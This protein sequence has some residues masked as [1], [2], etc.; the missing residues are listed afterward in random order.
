MTTA[1]PP[2]GSRTAGTVL[3]GGALA[4]LGLGA[5]A[6]LAL[7]VALDPGVRS[8]FDATLGPERPSAVMA[9]LDGFGLV[10]PGLVFAI[11]ALAVAL[12]VGV[13]RRDVGA[14][15]SA[16][17]AVTW[18]ALLLAAVS[19]VR[20]LQG[21]PWLVDGA[22]W[23]VL[24]GGV[25][26][27]ALAALVATVLRT[28]LA[29]SARAPDLREESLVARESRTAWILLVPALL[30]LLV[31]AARPLEATVITSLTDKRFASDDV[32]AFVG[33]AN[34]RQ[35]L[36]LRFDEVACRTDD[37]GACV[38]GPD[39]QVR[40]EALPRELLLDG[41]R[42]AFTWD[43]P[44]VTAPDRAIAV[45]AL[46]RTW[47][48]SVWVTLVFAVASVSLELVIGLFI[49][50]T[51]HSEFRGRGAMRAVMLVPWAIPTV[52]SAR[53]WEL[54]LKDSSAGLVNRVLM[55]TGAI[56]SPQAWLSAS[57]LQLPSA[58]MIDV[59]K[60]SPFM[61][62]LLLAGL[63]VI[64]KELYESARV[65]GASRVREFF[66]ITLP[67]LR[68]AIAVAL[69]FRTLDA[70]RVFD[71]FNVLFGRSEHSVSTYTYEALINNQQAGYASAIGVL[72]FFL[73]F[74]IA[75]LYVRFLGVNRT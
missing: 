56:E 43:L 29:R 59:W 33:L 45:N 44:L 63:Q 51:V 38:R 35:L 32:P 6:A 66:A 34:Y 57:G 30:I 21:T 26:G 17:D 12:G 9:F 67:L 70:L 24:S 64:P 48:R 50:M 62:L 61:A 19:V 58:I 5:V 39:G 10:L 65:D 23:A 15:R 37:D 68:P 74:G 16:R 40:W 49:A 69:I 71:L 22:A 13:A 3:L 7:L 73:I 47:W 75:M 55:L 60:T 52:V 18:L 1:P 36:S 20:V 2:A 54:M 46:D 25:A 53:L 27:P 42:T 14:L 11:G 28:A 31:V 72:I 4:A 8:S 41:Y